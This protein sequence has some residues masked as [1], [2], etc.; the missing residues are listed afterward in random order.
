MEQEQTF[1]S[2][3]NQEG[4]QGI[5]LPIKWN[6]PNDIQSHY[7][8]NVLVQ[9]GPYEII[10]SFFETQYPPL[11]GSP[12]ENKAQLEQLGAVQANC[13]SRIIVSPDLLPVI[14][15]AMQTSLN[16]YQQTYRT[17]RTEE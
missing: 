4:Q 11:A 16:A 15:D 2:D 12:E 14:I 7:A 8:N 9:S 3:M 10:I 6:I 17:P 5:T 1:M 13:V